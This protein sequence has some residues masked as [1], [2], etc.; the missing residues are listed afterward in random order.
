MRIAVPYENGQ[1]YQHFGHTECFKL[2]N[3]EDRQIVS[4]VLLPAGGSGHEALAS[5]LQTARVTALICGG[6][7]GGARVAL[8]EAGIM[9]FPGVV[10]DA[11]QAAQ[12]LAEGRLDYDPASTCHAHDHEGCA[13]HA[14]GGCHRCHE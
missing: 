6:I 14:E 13:H 9:L 4:T 2:Y 11:D 10:G 5:L 7:G 3:V 1:I 12:A 8:M